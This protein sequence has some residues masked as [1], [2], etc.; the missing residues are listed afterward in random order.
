MPTGSEV[1]LHAFEQ[2]ALGAK[3]LMTFY[4]V[5]RFQ[6]TTPLPPTSPDIGDIP[7]G[8]TSLA[9]VNL[10][11]QTV[12]T[13][14]GYDFIRDPGL[15]TDFFDADTANEPTRLTYY[16]LDDNG[17]V[18]LD[19]FSNNLGVDPDRLYAGRASMRLATY[20]LY[21]Y[22]HDVGPTL[23]NLELRGWWAKGYRQWRLEDSVDIDDYFKL[24]TNLKV[25]H[26]SRVG[27]FGSID[28]EDYDSV[29]CDVMIHKHRDTALTARWFFSVMNR[30]SDPRI[31]ESGDWVFRSETEYED[32]LA[33][34]SIGEY[35]Q[36]GAREIRLPF[37]YEAQGS[38]TAI[39]LHV[40][41][42]VPDTA[43]GIDTVIGAH[44]TLAIRLRPGQAK[45]FRVVPIPASST[46][47][48]GFLAHS[49]QRKI[50][51][52]PVLDTMVTAAELEDDGDTVRTWLRMVVG[53]T[54]RYHRVYHKRKDTTL[55]EG[56]P[57]T[58]WY[59]HSSPLVHTDTLPT[60]TARYAFD[61]STVTWENPV[62]ISSRVLYQP[63][64]AD[65]ATIMDLSCGFP[66][67]VV[68]VDT[69]AMTRIA[70]VYVVF[71]CEY[72]ATEQNPK[73]LVCE[74]VIPADATSDEQAAFYAN[75]YSAVL[76]VTPVTFVG[77]VTQANFLEHWG[78]PMINASQSGNY[79]CWS[80]E[81]N[82]IGAGLKEPHR[83]T[84]LGGQTE[85]IRAYN[86][87]ICTH[88]SMHSYSRLHIGE[89]DAGLVWQEGADPLF[90]NF[91][92]YTRLKHD[93]NNNIY[94]E[95][96]ADPT[97][98]EEE[99]NIILPTDG[100]IAQLTDIYIDIEEAND[101]AHHAFPLLYRQMSDWDL[102]G[103]NKFYYLGINNIKAERAYWQ[104]LPTINYPRWVI[105]R[106]VFDVREWTSSWFGGND[107]LWSRTANFIFSD[108][109]HLRGPDATQGEQWGEWGSDPEYASWD[110]DDSTSVLEFWSETSDTDLMPMLWSMTLSWELYGTD[111]DYDHADLV[112]DGSVR[113][114]NHIGKYPH[115]AS[116]YS[117]TGVNNRGWQRNRRIFNRTDGTWPAYV[118]APSLVTSSEYFYKQGTQRTPQ[119]LRYVGFRGPEGSPL[120]GPIY[121]H[122]KEDWLA[123]KPSK[124]DDQKAPLEYSCDWLGLPDV[125]HITVSTKAAGE[126]LEAE[127][128]V[129]RESD[130]EVI[131]MNTMATNQNG[132]TWRREFTLLS[133]P[134]ERYR[135]FIEPNKQHTSPAEDIE[136]RFAKRESKNKG[137]AN[138]T[139]I[140]LRK[141]KEFSATDEA[142]L[143]VYPNPAQN[144][145]TMVI[146][147][148]RSDDRDAKVEVVISSIIGA[149]QARITCRNIDVLTVNVETWTVGTYLVL[150]NT[151]NGV[152]LTSS[153]SVV[154]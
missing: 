145:V 90:G 36:R 62:N 72:D 50:V 96:C 73:V 53:D 69:F 13:T 52:F 37:N 12:P 151:S 29:F 150:V 105:A 22:L 97:P 86:G 130:G 137:S 56:G 64:G 81:A 87:M 16:F 106:R 9:N 116:R 19:L 92:L 138:R 113:L 65:S 80:H 110:Y 54:M 38:G 28:A 75:D 98:T 30:R 34:N 95:L 74:S 102:T 79:Y 133:S 114:L 152:V 140:D 128:W 119:A 70:K 33:A 35:D 109:Y 49:N 144:M 7:I 46:Q 11:I 8:V 51:A 132:E 139:I 57:L 71:G 122:N 101:V 111:T 121:L 60:G 41:E 20:R 2:L 1:Y 78:T 26:P 85:Y 40:T 124:F 82:G 47:G 21:R 147:N 103:E 148:G 117:M 135:F 94:H 77:M 142:D 107:T 3:G 42:L 39:N 100:T 149:T 99:N 15:G 17:D 127:L 146:N 153:F 108:D 88:P 63:P 23:A 45:F 154:R 31:L 131:N 91:I 48:T 68:R 118:H 5:S 67:L 55:P 6:C 18:N 126:E 112:A 83:R 129:Q 93:A 61:A 143:I 123:F 27:D 134:D 59:Q 66:A 4:C 120:T 89:D 32:L 104:T 10:G 24:D 115:L 76:D 44:A 136:I 84:F 25:A 125:G 43:V 14:T 141:M 58:V